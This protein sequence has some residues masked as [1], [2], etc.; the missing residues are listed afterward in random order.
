MS[1]YAWQR[2]GELQDHWIGA[3]RTPDQALN[4]MLTVVLR[5]RPE[6]ANRLNDFTLDDTGVSAGYCLVKFERRGALRAN[7]EYLQVNYRNEPA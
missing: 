2:D 5:G 3:H 6:L 7:V 1:D 4:A